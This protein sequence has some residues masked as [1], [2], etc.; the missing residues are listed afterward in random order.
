MI[1]VCD[2]G[3]ASAENNSGTVIAPRLPE[4]AI[5]SDAQGSFVYVVNKDN[6][7]ERRAV[8][9]GMVSAEGI[10]VIAGLTGRERIGAA[11]AELGL[12]KA[13]PVL[14]AL[15]TQILQGRV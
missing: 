4:S 6:R 1:W 7:V 5:L 9:T 3:F 15:L 13:T 11:V 2:S 12:A 14:K 10:A 8:R